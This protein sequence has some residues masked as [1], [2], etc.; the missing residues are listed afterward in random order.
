VIAVSDYVRD[1]LVDR[2]H[3]SPERVG[4]VPH[5]V[6]MADAAVPPPGVGDADAERFLFTA[7]SIRP[8]RGL[9][10]VI[11]AME[12]LGSDAPPLVIAGTVDA[13]AETY[14]SALRD[15]LARAGLTDRVRWA[16]HLD[17]AQMRWCFEHGAAFVMTSRVEA[18]PNIALE[19]MCHGAV[20]IAT[21]C[22][23]MP[24]FFGP[25]ASYYDAG[26]SSALAA[27]IREVF[28][29]D[30]ATCATR[31]KTARA[32]AAGYSWDATARGTITELAR[33]MR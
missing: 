29:Q 22:R 27:V 30:V 18:C 19:A 17:R 1:F 12:A 8:A 9:E 16:G 7:G 33:A 15:R 28:A 21:R 11:G 20:S 24:E 4:V 10:D 6:A 23:P 5:G 31:R 3:V 14:A 2:W 26:A 32:R 13:G 25:A